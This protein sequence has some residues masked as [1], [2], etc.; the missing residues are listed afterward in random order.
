MAHDFSQL[1]N[2]KAK[3]FW[4]SLKYSIPKLI[5]NFIAYFGSLVTI[6]SIKFFVKGSFTF[7]TSK[8]VDWFLVVCLLLLSI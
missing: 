6:F 5:I 2:I 8:F 3:I 7:D 4:T 1:D